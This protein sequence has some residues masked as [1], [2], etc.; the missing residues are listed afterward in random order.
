VQFSRWLLHFGNIKSSRTTSIRRCSL[1]QHDEDFVFHAVTPDTLEYGNSHYGENCWQL[2]QDI[3]K[4]VSWKCRHVTLEYVTSRIRTRSSS[5]E[6]IKPRIRIYIIFYFPNINRRWDNLVIIITSYALDD[7]NGSIPTREKKYFC[8]PV[9]PGRLRDHPP[10]LLVN[11]YPSPFLVTKQPWR[12]SG[13]L[14]PIKC[15]V[16]IA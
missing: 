6:D 8:C 14:T 7:R 5:V 3:W 12:K 15:R 1:Q 4:Q 2:H 13:R 9:R 16:K 10:S 11:G